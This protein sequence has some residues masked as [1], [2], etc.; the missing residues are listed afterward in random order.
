MAEGW[1]VR[2]VFPETLFS[3]MVESVVGFRGWR[4][5]VSVPEVVVRVSWHYY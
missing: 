4:S 2:V 1:S 5:V 3:S